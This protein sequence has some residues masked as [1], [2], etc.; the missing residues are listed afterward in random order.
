MSNLISFWHVQLQSKIN[1]KYNIFREKK[2]KYT[3][4]RAGDI[5]YLLGRIMKITFLS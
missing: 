2:T 5:S 3:Y 4:I 1:I